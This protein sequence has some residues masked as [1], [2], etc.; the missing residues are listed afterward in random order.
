MMRYLLLIAALL[1]VR[2][3][4]AAEPG[5]GSGGCADYAW[6]MKREFFLLGAPPLSVAS[7][8]EPNDDARFTPLDRP[9]RV[10]LRPQREITLLAE[11][12]RSHDA[13]TSH[14]GL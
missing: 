4:F 7:V 3:A 14:A 5:M 1:A 10:G 12:G 13:T 2:P 11:P 8:A 9:M 6:D